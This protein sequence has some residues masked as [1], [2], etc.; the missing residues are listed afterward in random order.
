MYS[1]V[2]QSWVAARGT[3]HV[4]SLNLRYEAVYSGSNTS[5]ELAQAL[6]TDFFGRV[7]VDAAKKALG[8]NFTYNPAVAANI[9]KQY[10]EAKLVSCV[11]IVRHW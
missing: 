8:K 3:S 1:L 9:N 11:S 5:P 10:Q 2:D 4:E 6:S 7:N